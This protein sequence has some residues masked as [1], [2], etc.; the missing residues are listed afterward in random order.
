MRAAG[1]VPAGP[2]VVGREIILG[3]RAVP[4]PFPVVTWLSGDACAPEQ[5]T[6]RTPRHVPPQYV[7]AHTVT[8]EPHDPP[9]VAGPPPPSRA[10][11]YTVGQTT[12]SRDASFDFLV[13]VD[14]IVYQQLDPL[15]F[16]SW[17]ISE[18]NGRAIGIELEQGPGGALYPGQLA[19]FVALNDTLTRENEMQRQVPAR[20]VNG[21]RVPIRGTV[22]RIAP[23]E[24][25]AT[26]WGVVGHRNQDAQHRGPGDPGDVVIQAL[27]DAGYEGFDLDAG[28]DRVVWAARQRA[29]GVPATGIPGRETV[30]ALKRA[31]R[32]AGLWV[33]RP[34][35]PQSAWK[36][37]VIAGLATALGA[38][39][40]YAIFGGKR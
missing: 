27:L 9:L 22:A 36:A 1:A 31:G 4:V 33:E 25:G 23:P 16:Y 30:A 13:G 21:V 35:D 20:L 40:A 15:R 7:A 11:S 10:C 26:W 12:S 29:L 17:N 37:P 28:E 34:G 6:D 3:G 18:A 24:N 19:T 8:G 39:L 32:P 14:G 2:R 5:V 38:G